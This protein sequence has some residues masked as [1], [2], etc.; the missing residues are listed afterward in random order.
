M[1]KILLLLLF[2]AAVGC[3]SSGS[4]AVQ[5]NSPVSQS[6][7]NAL[8]TLSNLSGES[9]SDDDDPSSSSVNL[10]SV[11]GVSLKAGILKK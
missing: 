5:N 11:N 3:S 9:K 10:F 8:S 4:S 2:V 7:A 6:E 1:K